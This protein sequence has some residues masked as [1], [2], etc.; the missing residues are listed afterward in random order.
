MYLVDFS[1]G[2]S[3]ETRL[4]S[5]KR[6]TED[7][8]V[9]SNSDDSD[10]WS[11]TFFDCPPVKQW[12]V[13][14]L[15]STCRASSIDNNCSY[16]SVPSVH[17]DEGTQYDDLLNILDELDTEGKLSIDHNRFRPA[18]HSSSTNADCLRVVQSDSKIPTTL[19]NNSQ[20][21][22]KSTSSLPHDS[23]STNINCKSNGMI[24]H[25]NKYYFVMVINCSYCT[26]ASL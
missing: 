9:C 13:N 1:V 4:S 6:A 15:T 16:Q 23:S 21:H 18:P 12:A 26:V 22:S 2:S 19:S 8:T 14:D 17:C 24:N 20:Q 25:N 5:N 7:R 10:S 3:L 11:S